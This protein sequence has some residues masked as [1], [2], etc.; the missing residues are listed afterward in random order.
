MRR[1]ATLIS[2]ALLAGLAVGRAAAQSDDTLETLLYFRKCPLSAELQAVYERPAEV[3]GRSRFLTITVTD[4]PAAFVQCMVARRA[5]RQEF[6]LSPRLS[7]QA[8]SRR[9]CGSDAHRAVRRLRRACGHGA[10][11]LR[12]VRRVYH[13]GLRVLSGARSRS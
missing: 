8:R 2:I 9:H 3:E 10:R 1:N 12:A 6:S 7:R 5:G 13:H 4:R 11:H